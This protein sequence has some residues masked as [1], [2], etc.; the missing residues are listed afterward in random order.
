MS[1]LTKAQ[2]TSSDQHIDASDVSV[3]RDD[4]DFNKLLDW[5]NDHNPFDRSEKR[6]KSLS[7]GII[8]DKELSCEKA[9]TVGNTI[10][11]QLDNMKLC[12]V[13]IK[14]K[15]MVQCLDSNINKVT[16][17]TKSVYI[18]QTVLFTRLTA[19]AGRN[20]DPLQNFDYELTTYPMSLFKDGV[21]RKAYKAA[22]RNE[23]LP[24]ET[25]T[26]GIE[27][28]IVHGGA[29]LHKVFWPQNAT[30]GELLSLYVKAARKYYGNCHIIFDGYDKASIKDSE[31]ERRGSKL[32][33]LE[34]QFSDDMKVSLKREEFLS[35]SKNKSNLIRKLAPLLES[36]TQ[37][38]T[39]STS[40]ADT[41]IVKVALQVV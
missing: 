26:D 9:E 37:L 27:K 18:N 22:T 23:I 34:V 4:S 17:D 39:M 32:K 35:N 28:R 33:Q 1:N 36:D 15:Y 20:E 12:E 31:H 21:M 11:E 41:D 40:D 2:N 38:V 8:A 14:R 5:L 13:K 19:L 30:Y 10:Q 24:K 7:T 16:V 3:A 6:L 29:F 25:S